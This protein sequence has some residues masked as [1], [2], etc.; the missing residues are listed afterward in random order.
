MCGKILKCVSF[1]PSFHT[2]YG[3][4]TLLML[5]CLIVMRNEVPEK[6]VQRTCVV[7]STSELAYLGAMSDFMDI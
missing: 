6:D 3:M 5:K 1:F 2:K 7:S 4:Y